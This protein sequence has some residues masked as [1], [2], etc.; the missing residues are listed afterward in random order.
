MFDKNVVNDSETNSFVNISIVS[1][2]LKNNGAR[3]MRLTPQG[4]RKI[5]LKIFFSIK[6][7]SSVLFQNEMMLQLKTKIV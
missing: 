4:N 2:N 3:T 7:F 5:N 6:K 1:G